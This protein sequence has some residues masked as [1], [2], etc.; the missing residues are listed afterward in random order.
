ML[1]SLGRL[2]RIRL[3]QFIFLTSI[4]LPDSEFLYPNK[5]ACNKC[6]CNQT[7]AFL[8]KN[9]SS[10]QRYMKNLSRMEINDN[11]GAKLIYTGTISVT[12]SIIHGDSQCSSNLLNFTGGRH[13]YKIIPKV[14]HHSP[15]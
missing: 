10:E 12:F 15:D 13:V 3:P 1:L 7:M 5:K 6:S 4:P 11:T 9:N 2:Y 14:D 8:S